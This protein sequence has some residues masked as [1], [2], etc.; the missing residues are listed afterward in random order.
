MKDD[1]FEKEFIKLTNI[2]IEKMGSLR[3]M[4]IENEGG[5]PQ[6]LVPLYLQWKTLSEV[7]LTY[8]AELPETIKEL[9]N[10]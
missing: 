7:M 4:I 9:R 8:E 6:K 2:I 1:F 3:E 10:E 5:D